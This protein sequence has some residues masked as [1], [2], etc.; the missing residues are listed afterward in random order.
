MC[1]G[2]PSQAAYSGEGKRASLEGSLV[3]LCSRNAR[4]QKNEEGAARCHSCS[5]NVHD[6]TVLVR[7]AQLRANL[8]RC[9]YGRARCTSVRSSNDPINTTA[10]S[11]LGLYAA[12]GTR[13]A[14]ASGISL[15]SDGATVSN[16]L[17]VYPIS[18]ATQ[19]VGICSMAILYRLT[20]SL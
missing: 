10:I 9:P 13:L 14:K 11:R 8:G 4:P 12:T 16:G 5:Q 20:E 15:R 19:I 18:C 2:G 17:A 7:C 1:S 6:E 3:R